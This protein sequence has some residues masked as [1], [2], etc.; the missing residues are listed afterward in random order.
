MNTDLGFEVAELPEDFSILTDATCTMSGLGVL[1]DRLIIT[2]FDFN[3]IPLET[4]SEHLRVMALICLVSSWSHD[5]K[6][7][8][9]CGGELFKIH[10]VFNRN[11]YGWK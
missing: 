5:V 10:F 9:A 7:R 6:M 11:I 4:E 2:I 1:V 3:F 8:T